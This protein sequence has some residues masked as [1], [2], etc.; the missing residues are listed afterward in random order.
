MKIGVIGTRGFPDVQGGIETHCQEL[1]SRIAGTDGN[2]VVV[3]R[4]IPY[5]NEKN[6]HFKY[7]NIRFVDINVPRNKFLETFLHSLF[8]SVHALFQRFDIVHYHNTGPG[9][10]IPVVKLS[11]A[12][13]VFT[14]HNISYTQQKWNSLAKKFLSRS[15]KVSIKRSDYVIFISEVIREEM[16]RK[17]SIDNH[18]SG[19]IFNGVEIPGRAR[20]D[21]FIRNLGLRRNGYILGVGRFLEEKGFD[22]LIKAF[23]KTGI[24]NMKLVL[25]GDTDYPT[26][27]SDSLK[28]LAAENDVILPGFVKGS[29]LNQLYSFA[30]LFVI[31]SFS[32][33]LPIALLEAMSYN[34]DVLASDIPAN[35]QIGL[36]KDD[37]FTTGDEKELGEAIIKKLSQ[38]N[39]KSFSKVLSDRFDWDKIV[40]DTYEI[41][42]QLINDNEN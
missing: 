27:Y 17:Y 5:L 41:Y 25:A 7:K 3:Y 20:D 22:Y 35:L 26:E 36:D 29:G 11:G 39:K 6:R 14:Y 10:F 12:K 40:K 42:K 13:V 34:L 24:S 32:E 28:K 2:Q 18:R 23:R 31:P 15:E 16:I 8:A 37:Y 4:R 21:D 19:V 33:G 9:F 30:R 1:Y 38:E